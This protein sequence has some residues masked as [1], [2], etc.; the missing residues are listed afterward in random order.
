MKIGI[1]LFYCILIS[2]LTFTQTM[3]FEIQGHRGCRGLL[4][5]NT[6]PAFLRA[7]DEGVKT[8]EMDVVITKDHKV[9]VSHDPFFNP[10]I[11]T[12]PAGIALNEET[13]GNIYTLNYRQVK[14]YDVGMRGNPKFPEQ[15]PMKVSKPLLSE[16]IKAAEKYAKEQGKGPILY[17][18]EIKSEEKEYGNSQPN[19]VAE[20][21][22]LV[23]AIISKYLPAERV[24]IQS[25][26]FNVLKYLHTEIQS[27]N[28]PKYSLS[29]LIEPFENNDINFQLKKLGFSTE[30]WSPYFATL[31]KTRVQELHNLGIRVIPWTVN[32]TKDMIKVK[33]MNCDGLITDYPNRAKNL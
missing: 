16:V 10:D 28:F 31:S 32:E 6:I 5:E 29:A 17:N 2:N 23:I 33:E 21:S 20:F 11:S 25:F 7:I 1:L 15:K 30:I 13:K 3:D 9:L 14:K 12:S 27:G 26:D 18:I 4:P 22:K 24:C 19:E 8:L